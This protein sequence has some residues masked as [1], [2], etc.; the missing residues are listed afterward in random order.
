MCNW[1]QTLTGY[2]G[3]PAHSLLATSDAFDANF[4]Y[5]TTIIEKIFG[6]FIARLFVQRE[7]RAVDI[8]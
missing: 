1:L 7:V 4:A 3:S 8:W 6:T 2:A 5:Q